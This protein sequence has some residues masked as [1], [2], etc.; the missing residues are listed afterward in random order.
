MFDPCVPKCQ[1]EA[2]ESIFLCNVNEQPLVGISR[3]SSW[4]FHS[5]VAERAAAAEKIWFVSTSMYSRRNLGIPISPQTHHCIH[6][7]QF[8]SGGGGG[9]RR[10][11][12]GL[13]LL[14]SGRVAQH[15]RAMLNQ[16]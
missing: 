5:K 9:L 10:D 1:K 14:R 2:E 7:A 11:R 12:G 16:I 15:H 13:L 6:M 4:M 3:V 8:D